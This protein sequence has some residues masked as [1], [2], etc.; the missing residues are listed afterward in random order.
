MAALVQHTRTG[1]S[2]C[3]HV[4]LVMAGSTYRS[5]GSTSGPQPCAPPLARRVCSAFWLPIAG[6][7]AGLIVAVAWQRQASATTDCCDGVAFASPRRLRP[8]LCRTAPP[9]PPPVPCPA[10]LLPTR[11]RREVSKVTRMAGKNVVRVYLLDNS[12]KTLLVEDEA[13]AQVRERPLAEGGGLWSRFCRL[14]GVPL[15]PLLRT[16]ASSARAPDPVSSGPP[17]CTR[18][19]TRRLC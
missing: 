18:Y 11:R 16:L 2:R 15:V 3:T 5:R 8:C 6:T 7:A 19:S 14:L 17:R 12:M 13:T 1:R 10:S 9:P 4:N